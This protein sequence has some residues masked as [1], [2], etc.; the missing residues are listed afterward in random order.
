[1]LKSELTYQSSILSSDK[2]E[3]HSPY[4]ESEFLLRQRDLA[5]SSLHEMVQSMKYVQHTSY[6]TFQDDSDVTRKVI[7]FFPSVLLQSFSSPTLPAH[8]LQEL[9]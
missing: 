9:G 2:Q 4:L 1:M 6:L 3:T 5:P 8:A 7:P